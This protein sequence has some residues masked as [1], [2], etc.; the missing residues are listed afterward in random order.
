LDPTEKTRLVHAW[1]ELQG[2]ESGTSR[3]DELFWSF[4]QMWDLTHDEPEIA[5][6]V[7]LTILRA[8]CSSKI[9]ESLS[10]G[11]LEDLLAQHG[12]AFIERIEQEA[13]ANPSFRRL[14]GGVWKN[15]MT[16]E[17]WS[18]VQACWDRRGWDGVPE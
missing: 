10:A 16:D 2:I 17:V 3:Y 12:P 4:G 7:I 9:L 18:R 6:D 5:L 13:A 1:I 14:L 8:D 15:T 11:P